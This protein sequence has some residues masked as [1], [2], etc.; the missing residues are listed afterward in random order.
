MIIFFLY[1]L[2][3]LS[4]LSSEV[5]LSQMQTSESQERQEELKIAL[6]KEKQLRAETEEILMN[7]QNVFDIYTHRYETKIRCVRFLTTIKFIRN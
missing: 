2:Y 7:R 3:T 5:L 1:C 4:R 6:S